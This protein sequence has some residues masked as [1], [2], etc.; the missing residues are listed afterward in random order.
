MGCRWRGVF[1]RSLS[2]GTRPQISRNATRYGRLRSPE[3]ELSYRMVSVPAHHK[4]PRIAANRKTAATHGKPLASIA[5]NSSNV[6]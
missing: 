2:Y 3:V 4:H 6:G 1:D 5:R